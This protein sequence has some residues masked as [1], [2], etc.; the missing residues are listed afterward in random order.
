MKDDN[1]AIQDM[2][3][4][5][6]ALTIDV[7]MGLDAGA[8]LQAL[9][10][11]CQRLPW[12][13]GDPE[14]LNLLNRT[15]KELTGT[16]G[17]ID[18]ALIHARIT[19]EIRSTFEAD[20]MLCEPRVCLMIIELADSA[21]DAMAVPAGSPDIQVLR[22]A[23]YINQLSRTCTVQDIEILSEG[24]L[25][26]H[27]ART[28]CNLGLK[29][30]V[31]KSLWLDGVRLLVGN[32]MLAE[33][34]LRR[35]VEVG[36]LEL[37]VPP[38][39]MR[40][41]ETLRA[42]GECVLELRVGQ[43]PVKA[44]RLSKLQAEVWR[45]SAAAVT[46]FVDMGSTRAK[47]IEVR[48]KEYR[49]QVDARVDLE[50]VAS[51]DAESLRG[52]VRGVVAHGP[53][54]TQVFCDEFGL[55]LVSKKDLAAGSREEL[56][57]AIGEAVSRLAIYYAGRGALVSEVYWSF[58]KM[59][60]QAEWDLE[61]LSRIA[62]QESSTSMPGQVTLLWEHEA[63]HYRFE[64]ALRT[65]AKVGKEKLDEQE[66]I[67]HE[68]EKKERAKD[69]AM[70]AYEVEKRSYDKKW[71]KFLYDTPERPDPSGYR[72]TPVPQVEDFYRMFIEMG[73][74][75]GLRNFVI[76]DAG[77]LSFDV[78][79]QIGKQSFGRS[80]KAGG[81]L[82]SAEVLKWGKSEGH[83][84]GESATKLVAEPMKIEACRSRAETKRPLSGFCQKETRRIYEEPIREVAAW[85]DAS[86]KSRKE[87]IPVL[88]TGG[89]FGNDFLRELIEQEFAG[90]PHYTLTS[91]HLATL[92]QA[93]PDAQVASLPRFCLATRGFGKVSRRSDIAF[94]VVGGALECALQ[95]SPSAKRINE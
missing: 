89:A 60:R 69:K 2:P 33:Q 88:L 9:S 68:N 82:L 61:A 65:L 14:I 76:V 50:S 20:A 75:A 22:R 53:T 67:L 66:Q 3:R 73:A 57:C 46:L 43:N 25:V 5:G 30:R 19:E 32:E 16:G 91:D 93:N 58:P 84:K 10:L 29:L 8:S 81:E 28:E 48:A 13:D 23:D 39:A 74:D 52:A 1:V 92:V 11:S 35:I 17:P 4:V 95:V 36:D 79:G 41:Y 15:L 94:D 45:P 31:R 49:P 27:P 6:T 21:L 80:F 62:T 7:R 86:P 59:E 70:A 34:S 51:L 26:F 18:S 77:G 78:Y 90:T 37:S 54:D 38:V 72:K 55:P 87:G 42:A 71:F 24:P 44:I 56:G 63:L 12:L 83:L 40:D 64:A 85:L 47:M